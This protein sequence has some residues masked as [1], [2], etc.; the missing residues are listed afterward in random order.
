MVKIKK[1]ATMN[2]LSDILKSFLVSFVIVMII[3]CILTAP[4]LI[5]DTLSEK[6]PDFTIHAFPICLLWVS[7]FFI[8]RTK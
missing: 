8:I 4:D 2:I 3:T 5:V 6:M 7:V 1:E